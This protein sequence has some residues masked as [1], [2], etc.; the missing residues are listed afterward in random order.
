VP[1]LKYCTASAITNTYVVEFRKLDEKIWNNKL[2]VSIFRYLAILEPR[3]QISCHFGTSFPDILLGR[4]DRSRHNVRIYFFDIFEKQN[5][6]S[7]TAVVAQT[8]EDYEVS[9]LMQ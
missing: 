6:I 9:I 5:W 1:Q 8:Y 2:I 7:M 4:R 3:F